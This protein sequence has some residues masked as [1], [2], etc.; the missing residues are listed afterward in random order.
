M[1][2]AAGGGR[3]LDVRNINGF[4]HVDASSD[5]TVQMS[6]RK[7]IRAETRED[8]AEAQRDVRLEFAEGAARVLNDLG[9]IVDVERRGYRYVLRGHSCPLGTAARHHPAV[10][11]AVEVMVASLVE[12]DVVEQC[13]RGDRP[14]C[15]F[16]IKSAK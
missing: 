11:H 4:I 15:C 1:A 3:T 8:L 7:E 16:E 2:F 6:I 12:G 14:K 9:G 13:D 5:S 10:C